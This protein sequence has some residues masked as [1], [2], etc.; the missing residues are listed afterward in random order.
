MTHDDTCPYVAAYRAGGNAYDP[1][2]PGAEMPDHP[3]LQSPDVDVVDN[4]RDGWTE[5]RADH[6]TYS[7]GGFRD[8]R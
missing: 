8:R 3:C 6:V 2:T 1:S 4:F 5:A 7:G